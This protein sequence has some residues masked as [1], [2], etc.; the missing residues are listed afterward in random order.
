MKQDLKSYYDERA[1][2]YD[3]VYLN[4]EEQEDLAEATGILQN[5][6][7][8][9][10]V[11]EFACGTGYWTERIGK[12]AKSVHATDVNKSVI[13]IAQERRRLDNVTYEVADMYDFESEK[14]FEGFFGGFIW[15]HIKLQ[16]LDRFVENLKKLIR[17]KGNVVFI[18]SNPLRD[19]CHD[20]KRVI[21]TDDIG[22][23]Y[24]K[25]K[26]ENG[27]E[28][29]VLKNFPTNDFLQE[30]LSKITNDLKVVRT[31]YYWI[32]FGE[33]KNKN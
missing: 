21:K 28:Y 26:I 14:R 18:D 17:P 29:L 11:L 8:S 30:K 33:M 16:D 4:P 2:E 24:Q 19:T 5:V 27:N 9:K 20:L 12:T 25:R 10:T 3:K 6:F 32:A 7:S 23:T 13:K 31:R 22:N 15:S 1:N